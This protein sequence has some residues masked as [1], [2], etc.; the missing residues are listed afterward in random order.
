MD[1]PPVPWLKETRVPCAATTTQ[2]SR[3]DDASE[4]H[5]TARMCMGAEPFSGFRQATAR[6][7]RT[8]AAWASAVAHLLDTRSAA[9]E[10]VTRVCA[11]LNTHPQ[12]AC[13]E[14]F[15]PARARADIKRIPVCST[16]QPGSGLHGAACALRCFTSQ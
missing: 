12:G 10:A 14:A 9:G 15:A 1:E 8:K 11:N 16:P 2:G 5:G 13:Y 3:V 4:R 6:I 7:R